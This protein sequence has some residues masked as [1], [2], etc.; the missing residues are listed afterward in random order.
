[1]GS[2]PRSEPSPRGGLQIDGS[3]F[4]HRA[5]GAALILAR[6][7][8]ADLKRRENEGTSKRLHYDI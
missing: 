4:A 5:S 2:L 6:A 3:R 8:K 7:R 1:M